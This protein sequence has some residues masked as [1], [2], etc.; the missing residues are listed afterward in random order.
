MRKYF[1]PF[2]KY[3][4]SFS[5][6]FSATFSLIHVL[7]LGK[8]DLVILEDEEKLRNEMFFYVYTKIVW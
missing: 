8:L 1:Q 5:L 4:L 7:E 6:H 3:I 2:I